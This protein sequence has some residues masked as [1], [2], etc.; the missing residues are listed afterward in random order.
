[1]RFVGSFSLFR[2]LGFVVL[3]ATLVCAGVLAGNNGNYLAAMGPSPLR[4][5]A[6][7]PVYDAGMVL[8]A[9]DMGYATETNVVEKLPTATRVTEMN[10][11][12]G[13]TPVETES[14]Q[15]VTKS[16]P[17][18]GATSVPET[19]NSEVKPAQSQITPQML[20][21]Y[22][23][24]NGTTDGG[25]GASKEVMMPMEFTPPAP[26][27]GTTPSKSS[28]TYLSPPAK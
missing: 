12:T 17:P 22:F 26:A 27:A 14:P 5:R 3:G 18:P 24:Q 20:L 16:T 11:G 9:L 2:P 15:P 10:E 23:K 21:R 4:F 7:A 28:A 1:M 25:T 6:A 8:P 13:F 19:Y